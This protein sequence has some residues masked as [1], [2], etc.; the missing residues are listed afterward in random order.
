MNEQVSWVTP[1]SFADRT[2]DLVQHQMRIPLSPDSQ[3]PGRIE[4]TIDQNTAAHLDSV[5][6]RVQLI[7]DSDTLHAGSGRVD[8]QGVFTAYLP[9][10]QANTLLV[11][12]DSTTIKNKSD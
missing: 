12:L 4:F 6:Y 3:L 2:A 10:K 1:A 8:P 5:T 9:Q 11:T 7:T